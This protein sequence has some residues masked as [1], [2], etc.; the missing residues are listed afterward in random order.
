MATFTKYAL[1][2]DGTNEGTG[3]G[4]LV[5]G[6]ASA[7][8]TAIHTGPISTTTRDE[9]WLYAA[10]SYTSSLKLYIEYGG[11]TAA[12]KINQTITADSGLVLVVPG[13]IVKGAA[14]PLVIKAWSNPG[15]YITLFGYVNRIS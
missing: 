9:V 13:L 8:A 14:S 4:V 1:F 6:T 7:S 11:S 10:N 5:V 12:Y 3:S 2:P 15:S